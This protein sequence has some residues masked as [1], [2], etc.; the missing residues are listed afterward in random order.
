[1]I[2][3]YRFDADNQK[4]LKEWYGY[5]IGMMRYE[6]VAE[7][8]HLQISKNIVAELDDFHLL[9]LNEGNDAG[10][11]AK[12]YHILPFITQLRKKG[13]A[14]VND[15]ELCLNFMY[16]IMLLRLKKVEISVE[17]L[18][19]QTEISKFLALLAENYKKN[20]NGELKF[21]E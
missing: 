3:S 18:Q 4:L 9:Y 14:G 12:F 11:A 15:I 6:N 21:N 1:M 17:T 19:A 10:Y 5:L 7:T 2:R 8:G 13:E 16:G 20:E